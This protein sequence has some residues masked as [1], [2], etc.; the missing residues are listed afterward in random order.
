MAATGMG[1]STNL[2]TDERRLL[3]TAGVVFG[4]ASAGAA[5]SAA[6]AD[7]M[8]LSELGP[9]NLNAYRFLPLAEVRTLETYYLQ[10]LFSPEDRVSLTVTIQ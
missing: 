4:L 7:A 9:L 2:R 6:A 1:A 5:M 10:H 3:G 8:F